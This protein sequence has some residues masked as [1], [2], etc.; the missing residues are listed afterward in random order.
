MNRIVKIKGLGNLIRRCLT[1]IGTGNNSSYYN[2]VCFIADRGNSINMKELNIA[3]C[4]QGPSVTILTND[5]I[6]SGLVTKTVDKQDLRSKML[7]L[8]DK[9]KA[10]AKE[11]KPALTE[12]DSMLEQD[13]KQKDIETFD[14]VLNQMINN[15]EENWFK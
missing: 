14:K 9:G 10:L 7:T 12:I 6:R 8:T 4:M 13:I 11:V 3:F 5:M 15:G 1:N 2:V